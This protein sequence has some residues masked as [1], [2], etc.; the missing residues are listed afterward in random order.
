MTLSDPKIFDEDD[1]RNL[2][3]ILRK[4]VRS[5]RRGRRLPPGAGS[6]VFDA[7]DSYDW[8]WRS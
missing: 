1:R 2:L 7:M 8:W 5:V 4:L 6:A 3:R